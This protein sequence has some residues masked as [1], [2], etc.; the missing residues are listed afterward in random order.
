[1]TDISLAPTITDFW[2]P[3]LANANVVSLEGL[4]YQNGPELNAN[5]FVQTDSAVHVKSGLAS[6]YDIPA[7]YTDDTF[8]CTLRYGDTLEQGGIRLTCKGFR[9]IV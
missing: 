1:L 2:V 4:H 7:A 6:R 5:D 9:N 8:T 3:S